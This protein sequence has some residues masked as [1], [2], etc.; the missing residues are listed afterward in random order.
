V[1]LDLNTALN[2][3][4]FVGTL[5]NAIPDLKN[6][7]QQAIAAEWQPE[8]FTRA[9]RTR[10]GGRPTPTACG[11]WSPSRPP[12]RRP[13]RQNLANAAN[14][15]PADGAAD[16]PAASTTTPGPPG[17]GAELDDEQIKAW[18]GTFGTLAHGDT[19][20]GVY[21]DAG[22][23]DQGAHASSSPPTTGCL[24]PTVPRRG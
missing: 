2:S 12:T 15:D 5:A 3:Y 7:L 4:G 11:S 22:A 20:G 8:Q 17:D 9:V 13:T 16:G 1:A 6:I 19:N 18:I 24:R 21:G 23:A 14:K 10:S